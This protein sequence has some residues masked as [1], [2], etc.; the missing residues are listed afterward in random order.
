MLYMCTP[1][2]HQSASDARSEKGEESCQ[3][4]VELGT[5]QIGEPHRGCTEGDYDSGV[6][7]SVPWVTFS[8]GGAFS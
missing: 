3:K 2:K 1:R 5:P 8:N 7:L 4:G 6:C